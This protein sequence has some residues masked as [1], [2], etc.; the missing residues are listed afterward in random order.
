M[1][2]I[3]KFMIQDSQLQMLGS[4][5]MSEILTHPVVASSMVSTRNLVI[6]METQQHLAQVSLP[7]FM[8]SNDISIADFLPVNLQFR[9]LRNITLE[10]PISISVDDMSSVIV[11]KSP[12]LESIHLWF[13]AQGNELSPHVFTVPRG[14]PSSRGILFSMAT[15]LT[16]LGYDFK[17]LPKLVG[18]P[19]FPALRALAMIDCKNDVYLHVRTKPGRLPKLR[20]LMITSANYIPG[21][22]I[23]RLI[24]GTSCLRELIVY[25]P[26][27]YFVDCSSLRSHAQSLELLF[28]GIGHFEALIRDTLLSYI[29]E[30]GSMID[31][32]ILEYLG[33]VVNVTAYTLD[34]PAKVPE[35]PNQ[36]LERLKK[37]LCLRPKQVLRLAD[38]A[39]EEMMARYAKDDYYFLEAYI[40]TMTKASRVGISS[41]SKFVACN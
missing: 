22:D 26:N 9:S 16:I 39:K 19:L 40:D 15:R 21:D 3:S 17:H 5:I 4:G 41:G 24:G 31:D 13:S 12:S 38:L 11:E 23:I 14:E 25:G 1:F 34:L 7:S 2:G 20:A 33:V 32:S 35:G 6:L 18:L 29:T 27:L 10:L 37:V 8:R 36:A 30:M 28:F